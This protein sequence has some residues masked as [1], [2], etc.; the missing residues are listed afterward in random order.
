MATYSEIKAG[1]DE[2]AKQNEQSRKDIERSKSL[3]SQA[4]SQ[5]NSMPTVYAAFVVDVDS[6]A[7]ANPAVEAFQIAK[8]EKDELVSDFQ[9]LK[10]RATAIIAAVDG[11]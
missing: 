11:M 7:T 10:T 8:S 6:A 3:L 2:I 4:E 1:L 5:L 9:A